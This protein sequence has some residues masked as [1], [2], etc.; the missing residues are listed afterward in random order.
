MCVGA[1]LWTVQSGLFNTLL[2]PP[3]FRVVES[4]T[5]GT[6]EFRNS[7]FTASS[8]VGLAHVDV[9]SCN[10]HDSISAMR[11]F[12]GYRRAVLLLSL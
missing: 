5:A 4:R 6:G 11:F 9:S 7:N 3:C 2:C 10:H 8:E 1:N 12:G